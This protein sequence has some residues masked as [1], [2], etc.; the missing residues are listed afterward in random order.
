MIKRFSP[1]LFILFVTCLIFFKIFTRGFYPIPGDLLVS[2]YFPW[3]SGGWDGY[4]PFTFH[5]ELLNADSIRQIYPWKEF[6]ARE[7]KRGHFPNWNPFTFSGQPLAANLQSGVYYP[8]G[9]FY[10]FTSPQN[11]WIL[12]VVLQPLLAGAFMYLAAKSFKLSQTSSLFSAIVF[13]FSSYVITWIEN[14]NIIH[15]YIWL[16]LALWAINKFEETKKFRFSLVIIISLTFSILAGHPQTAIYV[17]IATFIYWFYKFWKYPRKNLF[18]LFFCFTSAFL[19]SAIQLIPTAAFYKISPISLPFSKEVFDRSIMPY[20]S[21]LTFFASDFFGHP[22]SDNFWSNTYGD[23][24]PHLGVIP[25]IFAFWITLRVWT[26]KYK[27]N[28][29]KFASVVSLVFIIATVHSPITYL[30]RTLEIPLLDSTTP[31]RFVSISLIFLSLLAAFGFEDFTDNFQ[32][33]KYWRKFLKFLIFFASIYL[34]LWIFTFIGKI[35]LNPKQIWTQNLYVTQKN[36]ILPTSMVL[37]IPAGVVLTIFLKNKLNLTRLFTKR[38]VVIGIFS[39]FIIG[40]IYYSN[41]FLPVA[42]KKFIFPEHPIINWMKNNA[43]IDRFY[44][45]GVSHIDFSFPASYQIYAAEGY[46]SLRYERYAQLM[47]SSY[48]G[49]VPKT[50]LRSE[51]VFPTEEN[52][53]RKRLLDLLGIKYFLDKV[54]D[55][56]SDKDWHYERFTK[57]SVE[58]I[59]QEGKFQIYKRKTPLPRIFLT[60]SYIVSK[61]SDEIIDYIY[62]QKFDLKTLIL[63]KEPGVKIENGQLDIITP[64]ILTYEPDKISVKTKAANNTLLFISDVYDKDWNVLIDNEKSEILRAD[65]ALRAVAIPSGEHTIIFTYNPKSFKYGAVVTLLS[66]ISLVILYSYSAAKKKF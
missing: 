57:D 3:N 1:Y 55:P 9:I 52:G 48:T 4:N 42:P 37:S 33:S 46:D 13:M 59:W 43:G 8:L 54:D 25:L 29:V 21:L 5:K 64:Q 66:T 20:K 63:E 24:T 15:S 10:F 62:D 31:S 22:A 6:A 34:M 56:K 26:K 32:N 11:A 30:I 44:G 65:Y 36:L 53:Y 41:K 17:V 45:Q 16:P 28:F 14:V 2:F 40:G 7:F 49:K 12:L 58:G 38:L 47:A 61:N 50:Y 18:I 23:F 27:N 19:L 51:A 35:L 39:M 60:T